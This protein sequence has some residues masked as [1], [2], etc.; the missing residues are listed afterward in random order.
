MKKWFTITLGLALAIALTACG[1]KNADPVSGETEPTKPLNIAN[2]VNPYLT[3]QDAEEM[4][5]KAGFE[6]S[7]PAVLPDWVTETIYRTIPDELIEVIYAGEGN[8]LRVR[9]AMGSADISGV[10]DTDHQEAKE[11][12]IQ[13]HTVNLKG[14]TRE[15]GGF[16]VYVCTWN[17]TEGRTYSV[18]CPQG[19]PGEVLLPILT[20]IR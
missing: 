14:E 13:D 11:A 20:E 17:T 18:T 8:E 19:I 6:M 12:V 16:M 3:C 1:A 2:M 5:E 9:C 4:Q 15:D 10:Y 7:L